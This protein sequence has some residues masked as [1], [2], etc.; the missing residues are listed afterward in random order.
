MTVKLSSIVP[1]WLIAILGS[2]LVALLSPQDEYFTWLPIVFTVATLATFVIQLFVA[3]KDGLVLRMMA[4]IGG[5]VVV[6]ALA[7]G[8][9]GL[10]AQPF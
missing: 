8:I 6:L 5:A 1:V 3:T 4:S 9:L 7:T 2:V 10:V